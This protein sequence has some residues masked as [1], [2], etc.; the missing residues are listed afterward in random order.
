MGD[1][2]FLWKKITE[3]WYHLWY[4]KIRKLIQKHRTGAEFCVPGVAISVWESEGTAGSSKES[5]IL[6]I[7]VELQT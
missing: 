6:V 4:W 2:K 5:G 7:L 3:A 1:K